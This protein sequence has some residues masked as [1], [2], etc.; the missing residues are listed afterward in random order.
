[1]RHT[2]LARC[3]LP[4]AAL[5][6]VPAQA[7][8]TDADK[9]VLAVDIY[10]DRLTG[11]VTTTLGKSEALLGVYVIPIYIMPMQFDGSF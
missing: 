10:F 7:Q 5:C 8:L 4:L 1:M 9:A 2:A 11:R 3:A 6:A